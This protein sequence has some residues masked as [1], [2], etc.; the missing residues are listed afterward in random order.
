MPIEDFT[1]QKVIEALSRLETETKALAKEKEALIP[2]LAK[3]NAEKQVLDDKER[4][5][6]KDIARLETALLL[7]QEIPGGV[8]DLHARLDEARKNSAKVDVTVREAV[9]F[10]EEVVRLDK[11]LIAACQHPLIAYQDGY[12]DTYSAD[13]DRSEPGER[14][15]AICG[16]HEY[17]YGRSGGYKALVE[18]DHR[19]FAKFTDDIA[20][21]RTSFRMTRDLKEILAA[22]TDDRTIALLKKMAT[23]PTE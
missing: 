21:Q 9:E 5:L 4:G 22:F 18:A 6:K 12:H 14:S 3:L 10:R 23:P 8:C 7:L 15:C 13:R 11:A 16:L 19:L 17:E 1:A 2:R 20:V